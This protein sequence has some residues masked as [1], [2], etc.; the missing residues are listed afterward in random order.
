MWNYIFYIAFL[1]WK[2]TT[3]Y[4]GTESYIMNKINN[5]DFSWFPIKKSLSVEEEEDSKDKKT[6]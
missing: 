2:Q 5:G 6:V 4:D 1:E 3:E